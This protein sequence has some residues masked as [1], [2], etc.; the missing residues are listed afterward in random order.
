VRINLGEKTRWVPSSFSLCFV[1]PDFWFRHQF[2]RPP[3]WVTLQISLSCIL[4]FVLRI[5]VLNKDSSWPLW[6]AIIHEKSVCRSH[7]WWMIQMLRATSWGK[8]LNNQRVSIAGSTKVLSA[9]IF[10]SLPSARSIFK[11]KRWVLPRHILVL[12]IIGFVSCYAHFGP[13]IDTRLKMCTTA[14]KV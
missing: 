7:T 10:P 4:F 8:V 5:H 11:K 12:P 3:P 1:H 14:P 6:G 13:V 9:Y 2:L